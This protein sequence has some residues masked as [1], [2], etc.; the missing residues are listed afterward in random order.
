MMEE[1]DARVRLRCL[2]AGAGAVEVMVAW[3]IGLEMLRWSGT[4]EGGD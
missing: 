4:V 1:S 3:E 2:R